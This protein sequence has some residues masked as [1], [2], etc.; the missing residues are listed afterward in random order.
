MLDVYNSFTNYC[1]ICSKLGRIMK[2]QKKGERKMM[3]YTKEA[4]ESAMSNIN[5][6]MSKIATVSG[7]Q[8]SY[9]DAAAAIRYL[10]MLKDE[11]EKENKKNSILNKAI[12]NLK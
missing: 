4:R 7:D 5:E 9:T 6:L 10:G 2:S 1:I 3:Y 12:E 11:I 8:L